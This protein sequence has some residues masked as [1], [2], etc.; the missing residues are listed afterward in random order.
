MSHA[1]ILVEVFW[2]L[3]GTQSLTEV[4]YKCHGSSAITGRRN[5]KELTEVIDFIARDKALV[6][7]H[8]D[9]IKCVQCEQE[10]AEDQ[11]SATRW[12]LVLKRRLCLGCSGDRGCSSCRLRGGSA[13]FSPDEWKKSEDSRKCKNCTPKRCPRCRKDKTKP[14]SS[15]EQWLVPEGKGVCSDCD[16]RRCGNCNK[17]KTM[18][19]FAPDMWEKADGSKDACCRECAQGRRTLGMWTCNNKRCKQQ[20]PHAAFQRAIERYGPKV[21]GNARVCDDCL[22]RREEEARAMA[23]RNLEHLDKK[24]RHS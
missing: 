7:H 2:H 15:Q 23:K 3:D 10:K 12:N 14:S 9:S 6:F 4:A 17:A 1:S 16:R 11:F 13:K 21:Q 8:N 22:H 19:D 20:K 24:Q 5:W 18:K